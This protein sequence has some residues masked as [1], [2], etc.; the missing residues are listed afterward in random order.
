[1]SSTASPPG[2]R[3]SLREFLILVTAVVVGCASLKF[4][5]DYWLIIVSLTTFFAFIA[6]AIV[7]LIDRGSR[8]SI[9]MGFILA[10]VVYGGLLSSQASDGDQNRAVVRNPEFDPYDGKLPTT[11][12][13]RPLFEAVSVDWYLDRA[14]GK[15]INEY[16]L[17]PGATIDRYA[18][19]GGMGGGGGGMRAQA[20]KTGFGYAG[21]T[22]DREHFM[23]IAHCLWALL[24]GYAGG[25]FARWVYF[26]RLR[27]QKAAAQVAAG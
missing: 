1:M 13:M 24:F 14:T 25:H 11:R 9:A 4:A 27:E 3:I 17:P 16:Q 22:P 7:A 8:Q 23:P 18:D 20:P 15:R 26:R 6:A 21:Q 12:I 5:N 19:W 2:L 10:G